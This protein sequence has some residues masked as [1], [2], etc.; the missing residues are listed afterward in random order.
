VLLTGWFWLQPVIQIPVTETADGSLQTAEGS[1]ETGTNFAPLV[2]QDASNVAPL[3]PDSIRE[4]GRETEDESV[5]LR[6]RCAEENHLA[7]PQH[8]LPPSAI[9][10]LLS[11]IWLTGMVI[12]IFLATVGYIRILLLLR[13][14]E[15][16][17]DALAEPWRKLLTEHGFAPRTVPMF[18]S[19]NLGPALILTPFGYR[20]AIPNDLWSELSESGRQGI[21][22]HELGRVYTTL[23]LFFRNCYGSLWN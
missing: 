12:T 22:K 4:E 9:C 17:E 10:R 21:L 18:L 19:R 1:G 14:T 16:A 8:S 15:P 5:L 11:I 7:V 13:N 3:S 20:L 6:A 2:A 23:D